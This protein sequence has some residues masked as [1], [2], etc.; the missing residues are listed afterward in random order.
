[1]MSRIV[2]V[3][4]N[5]SV[6]TRSKLIAWKQTISFALAG[7]RREAGGGGVNVARAM[8]ELGGEA[9]AIV[10]AGGPSGQ[11]PKAR[12]ADEDV[13]YI[14]VDIEGQTREFDTTNGREYRFVLPGPQLSEKECAALIEVVRATPA[15]CVVI[16]GSLPEG[17]PADFCRR[18]VRE[19]KFAV[20]RSLSTCRARR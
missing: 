9:C 10:A 11:M 19:A 8:R 13:P 17:A 3:T 1:M 5:P 16:S 6:D 18:L 14:S 2:T 15:D 20:R 4:V 7:V 12:L